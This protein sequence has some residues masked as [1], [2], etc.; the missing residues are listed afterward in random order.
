[1][2]NTD[3]LSQLEASRRHLF[4]SNTDPRTTSDE[5]Y[6]RYSIPPGLRVLECNEDSNGEFVPQ[7]ALEGRVL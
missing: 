2:Y 7:E 4:G 1:M 6:N 5:A 3:F